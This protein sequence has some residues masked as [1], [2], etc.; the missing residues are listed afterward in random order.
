VLALVNN[1][2]QNK[3]LSVD[4]FSK[5]VSEHLSGLDAG[6]ADALDALLLLRKA[7]GNTLMREYNRLLNVLG[8]NHPRSIRLLN[9]I[10]VNTGLMSDL[11][12][13]AARAKIDLP[14]ANPTSWIL[15]GF[16]RDKGLRGVAKMTVAL[17]TPNGNEAK[18]LGR[19]TTNETGH[20]RLDVDAAAVSKYPF[21]RAHV[22][23]GSSTIISDD[24][25]L[26]PKAGSVDYREMVIDQK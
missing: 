19:A 20:Y 25:L 22:T 11:A 24:K 26:Q 1:N 2:P 15:S 8:P 10:D 21:L 12:A 18:E 14:D 23:D 7:K 4:S 5:N 16:V 6:R 3:Y 13:E 17:Y 9:K